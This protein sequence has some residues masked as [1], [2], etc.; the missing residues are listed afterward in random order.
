MLFQKRKH[1]S[2]GLLVP[3]LTTSPVAV[4]IYRY[5]L[6]YIF[7]FIFQLFWKP[8][9]VYGSVQI[10]TH[11]VNLSKLAKL[12]QFEYNLTFLELFE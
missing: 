11:T 10:K 3:P 12:K 8:H 6:V 1:S 7:Y 5:R 9:T 4:N 2:N